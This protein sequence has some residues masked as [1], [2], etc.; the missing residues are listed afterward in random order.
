VRATNPGWLRFLLGRVVAAV[1]TLG[2]VSVLVFAATDVLPG[3]ASGA[4]AGADATAA[5]R[6]QIRAEL[7]LD[8]PAVQRY[9]EWAGGVLHG[10]LGTAFV[11]GRPV[12]GMLADRLPNSLLLA[13]VALAVMIPAAVALGLL[14]G[15]RAG[16]RTDRV[17]STVTL[18]AVGVPEFLTAAI[19]VAGLATGLGLLPEVSLVPLGGNPLDDPVILVLPA[20]TLVVVGLALATRMIRASAAD[21][22]ATPYVEAARLNGV[23]GLRLA[24]VHVLPNALGPA[25]QVLATTIGGLVGGAV[26][27]ETF[28]GYPGVGFELQQAVVRRDV[29]VVQGLVMVLAAVSLT[30]LLAGDVAR[31]LVDG[32]RR[33][34]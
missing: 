28:F 2:A 11:G 7:G 14:A 9:L 25:V 27:V 19:L 15:M 23:R 18:V 16:R 8:R 3:D 20:L 21:V 33:T 17:V 30:A 4:L 1:L 10:D 24:L 31:R 26:V 12:A 32:D 13:G 22:A 34:A 5:Q 6:A 29:P